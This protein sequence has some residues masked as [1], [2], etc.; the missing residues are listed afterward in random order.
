MRPHLYDDIFLSFFSPH[1]AISAGVGRQE[2][3]VVPQR[4]TSFC[5]FIAYDY[6]YSLR[7]QK[8]ENDKKRSPAGA[9]QLL[10][11]LPTPAL[12]AW[13]GLKNDKKM[14]SHSRYQG[15]KCRILPVVQLAKV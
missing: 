9:R 2:Y 3:T 5:H 10:L 1:Q 14:S 4:G 11:D 7:D 15:N 8:G 13:C 12:I 6:L